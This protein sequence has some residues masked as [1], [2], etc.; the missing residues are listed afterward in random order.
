M[1][2]L[3]ESADMKRASR[4]SSD[5][6]RWRALRRKD[7]G[8]DGEFIYAVVT[9]GIFCRPGCGAKLPRRENVIF[10]GSCLEAERGGF[11]PCKRCQPASAP[12]NSRRELV[13]QACR[14]IMTTEQVPSV[15]ELAKTAELSPFHFHRLFK[16]VVGLTP[17][18]FAMGLRDERARIELKQGKN[19]TGAIYAAGFNANSRFYERSSRALGMKPSEYMRGG[20]G[21]KIR[22][23][24]VRSSL[25][26][27]LVAGTEQG[28]CCVHFGETKGG[29]L[30][31]LRTSF[32]KADLVDG[33]EK[34]RAWV[35]GV[36]GAIEQSETA[37]HLPLDIRGTVFQ[38]QVWQSLRNIPQG[39]TLSYRELAAK[40]GKPRSVRAVAR[41]CASNPVAVVVPCHRVVRTDG[42]LAG[43]RWG[44]E[45][46][47][48]LLRRERN[49]GT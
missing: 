39:V 27:V 29:L 11:R 26:P 37:V 42:S 47:R 44:I 7:T 23:G 14:H 3:T 33:D 35:H 12:G 17:R 18:K 49:A 5:A 36:V 1:F 46:K 15:A 13:V 40:L 22:Y 8:A 9:T 32:P 28:I 30:D 21:A 43:Y 20:P 38:H 6:A 41:A 10:F 4:F 31:Y 48:K 2:A 45:R 19:V 16:E 34:F 25:G 24:I